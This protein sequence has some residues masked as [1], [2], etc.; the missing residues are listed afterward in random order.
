MYER[1]RNDFLSKPSRTFWNDQ[2][3]HIVQDCLPDSSIIAYLKDLQIILCNFTAYS[4]YYLFKKSS[5]IWMK[6]KNWNISYVLK[7]I[8]TWVMQ[9]RSLEIFWHLFFYQREKTC[10]SYF[11]DSSRASWWT[12]FSDKT[13]NI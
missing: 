4:I 12:K 1:N 2:L 11:V 10:Y 8:L 3:F 9:D 13:Y 7:K 6:K 5:S